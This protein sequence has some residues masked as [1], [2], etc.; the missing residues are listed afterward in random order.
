MQPV[1]TETTEQKTQ[2][3]NKSA[4]V[5]LLKNVSAAINNTLY[6]SQLSK[7]LRQISLARLSLRTEK[8]RFFPGPSFPF[9]ES[10]PK[11]N[12]TALADARE[13]CILKH[14]AVVNLLCHSRNQQHLIW[15]Q[16]EPS[17]LIHLFCS[18]IRFILVMEIFTFDPSLQKQQQTE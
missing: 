2:V 6:I 16:L 14:I 13:T 15:L 17:M 1:D 9:P 8:A 11:P 4:N 3:T 10:N 18:V 5:F 7:N 12:A